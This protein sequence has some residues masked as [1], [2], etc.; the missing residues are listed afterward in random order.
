MKR[1]AV[2]DEI[3]VVP[4][5]EEATMF[6]RLAE[7]HH[8]A[9][10]AREGLER[11]EDIGIDLKHES[12][13]RDPDDAEWA[14]L[15]RADLQKNQTAIEERQS[16]AAGDAFDP[17][18]FEAYLRKRG[19]LRKDWVIHQ[20]RASMDPFYALWFCPTAVIRTFD[21]ETQQETEMLFLD[22][23]VFNAMEFLE[24]RGGDA[25]RNNKQIQIAFDHLRSTSNTRIKLFALCFFMTWA[26]EI[27]DHLASLYTD[28]GF[29]KK[30]DFMRAVKVTAEMCELLW[31][32]ANVNRFNV[33]EKVNY[34]IDVAIVNYVRPPGYLTGA[35]T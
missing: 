11:A 31:R 7:E 28:T 23:V 18:R 12:K 13:E 21:P 26:P 34:I 24:E 25:V 33:F 29:R 35:A 2:D 14:L 19:V 32:A 20:R 22:K 10:R 9:K 8:A 6:Q 15:R 30:E 16:R 3:I 4:D 27:R 1:G 17:I 5:A